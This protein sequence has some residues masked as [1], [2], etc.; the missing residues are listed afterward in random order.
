MLP[1]PYSPGAGTMP[2]FLAGRDGVL[3]D[4]ED[5]LTRAE[6]FRRGSG[7]LVWTGVRGV[8]KT[9]TLVEARTRAGR[10]GFL[11]AHVTADRSGDLPHR[12]AAAIGGALA[13][14][15]INRA[16]RRWVCISA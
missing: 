10:L 11:A 5:L 8:G 14:A 13:N 9:V 1:S 15:D 2:P 16:G 4:V 3:R 6:H 7:P 12:L